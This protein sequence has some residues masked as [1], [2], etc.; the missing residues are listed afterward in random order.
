MLNPWKCLD[1][2]ENRIMLSSI[3]TEIEDI[4]KP[5]E[6]KMQKMK[7]YLVEMLYILPGG[8]MT[9]NSKKI[10][11]LP[12]RFYPNLFLNVTNEV[13]SRTSQQLL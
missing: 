6:N 11:R 4:C 12:T 10:S 7:I 1:V 5:V 3:I 8:E 13:D 2:C 9:C